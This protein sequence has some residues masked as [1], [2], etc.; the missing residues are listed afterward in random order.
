VTELARAI[1]ATV[2][3][4]KADGLQPKTIY[5]TPADFDELASLGHAATIG[6]L[7]VKRSAGKGPSKIYDRH[8]VTRSVTLK[9]CGWQ[10]RAAAAPKSR[11]P[12]S[13]K[14]RP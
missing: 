10:R 14:A 5:A 6:G 3:R 11:T 4:M 9:P 1:I 2:A 12:E 7:Q 8:G 13:R